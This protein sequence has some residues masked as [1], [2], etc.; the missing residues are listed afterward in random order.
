MVWMN[1]GKC[2]NLWFRIISIAQNVYHLFCNM[3]IAKIYWFLLLALT[4]NK[5]A[6]QRLNDIV[7]S[8]YYV[9][10]E[11]LHRSYSVEADLWS[12]GVISYILLCGS[13]PFWARTESGIFRSVLRAN[14]NFDDTP[15]PSISPEAKDFVKRLLNKDHRK[16]MTAAQALCMFHLNVLLRCCLRVID[17]LYLNFSL[18]YTLITLFHD[19]CWWRV[20]SIFAAHPWLR[21]EKI[22]IPLDILIY[23]LVKSYVRA[24]PLKRAALKVA[25]GYAAIKTNASCIIPSPCFWWRWG[26][27]EQ[28]I[29]FSILLL[30]T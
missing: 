17:C 9:A 7:G 20:T 4:L 24:S 8:A 23:K 10:P 21:N 18:T 5:H 16:R 26:T 11:V 12:I 22:A 30:F 2:F 29:M 6:D 13:R 14:P 1:I 19:S 27:M 3:F 25:I 28:V 15:W